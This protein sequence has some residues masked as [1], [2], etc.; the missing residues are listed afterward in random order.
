MTTSPALSTNPFHHASTTFHQPSH[1]TPLYPPSRWKGG[2]RAVEAPPPFSGAHNHNTTPR[3]VGETRRGGAP[4]PSYNA[5][6]RDIAGRTGKRWR[7]L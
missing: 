3:K 4:P 6:A 2:G 1:H 7:W 5:R